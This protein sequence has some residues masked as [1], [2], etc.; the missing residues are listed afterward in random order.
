M[1]RFLKPAVL[2]SATGGDVAALCSEDHRRHS[3]RGGV[4]KAHRRLHGSL[5]ERP[6]CAAES[7]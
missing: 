6:D 1:C 3:V 5:P 2:R 7:W 4:R